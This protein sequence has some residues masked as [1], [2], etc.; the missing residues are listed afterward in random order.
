MERI[1]TS[2]GTF[3]VY[4]NRIVTPQGNLYHIS[5]VDKQNKAQVA[6]LTRYMN[7]WSFGNEQSLPDWII[8]LKG[9]FEIF[10]TRQFSSDFSSSM[11]V[12]V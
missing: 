5:F 9:Q 11:A 3:N 10:I 4:L 8:G 6:I 12:A 7:Q 2:Y 1:E